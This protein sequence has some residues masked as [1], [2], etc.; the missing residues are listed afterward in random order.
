[1]KNDKEK[2][3]KHTFGTGVKEQDH[4]EE[5]V[6]QAGKSERGGG[7]M[8]EKEHSVNRCACDG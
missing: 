1:M 2:N 4:V 7:E 3:K 5:K 6:E 8:S